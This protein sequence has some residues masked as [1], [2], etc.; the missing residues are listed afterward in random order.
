MLSLGKKSYAM[1]LKER[2][3]Q[4]GLEDQQSNEV[5]S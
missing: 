3:E 2:R 1:K 4:M 5:G